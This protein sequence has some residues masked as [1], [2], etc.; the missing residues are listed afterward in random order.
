MDTSYTGPER[1]K[2]G[3]PA[4]APYDVLL[5]RLRT[6][7]GPAWRVGDLAVV[8]GMAKTKVLADIDCGRLHAFA[9]PCGS[10][11]EF[12]VSH[13]HARRYAALRGVK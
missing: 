6:G 8:I 12:V 9:V 2:P 3:R 5:E 13:E 11:F 4:R 10:R 7:V 1:R